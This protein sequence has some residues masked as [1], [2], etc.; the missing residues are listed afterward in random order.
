[1]KAKTAV[2][3]TAFND[4]QTLGPM[5]TLVQQ[6]HCAY[7]DVWVV[8]D[9]STDHTADIIKQRNC[10]AV[11]LAAN[12]GV[13]AAYKAGFEAI[14]N[15]G[16]YEYLIKIDAD[17]QHRPEFIIQ[18]IRLLQ[19]GASIAVCSR[20]HPQSIHQGTPLD[21]VVLNNLFARELQKTT[22]MQI[23]DAR[24]GYFGIPVWL[25]EKITPKLITKG[26]GIPM[27]I[28]LRIWQN[29][30]Q[31]LRLELPHPA[32]YRGHGNDRRAQQYDQED[33]DKKLHRFMEA[34][35][36]LI[37]VYEDMGISADDLI[38][39]AQPGILVKNRNH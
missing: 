1:M 38:N 14:I 17:G 33:L 27:E 12:Q 19:A 2:M 22:G 25:A 37:A 7:A 31:A 4:A 36:A 35:A 28:V 10:T 5:I 20:F 21:R 3:F 23:T 6:H 24:S 26:Y 9:G 15:H 39:S 32:L 8:N 11:T 13:G 16:R 18:L 30:P 34:F 29:N